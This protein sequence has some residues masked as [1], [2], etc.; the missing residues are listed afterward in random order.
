[1]LPLRRLALP[2]LLAPLLAAG[3]LSVAA[4]AHALPTGSTTTDDV[5]LYDHCQQHSISY[6]LAVDP[7][8]A[9]WHLDVLLHD[10]DG[11]TSEQ[12]VVTSATSPTRGTVSYAFCGSEKA[13]T[14]TVEAS[15]FYQGLP[16]VQTPFELPDTTFTVRPVQT[17]TTLTRTAADHG[18]Y[19]LAVTVRRE[20]EHGLE[21]AGGAPIRLERLVR[22]T[23]HQV[24]GLSLTAVRGR[25][26]T[27]LAGRPGQRVRAV[28]PDR[29]SLAGSTSKVVTL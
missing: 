11:R 12:R 5:V 7:G 19:R 17:R 18:R 27:V 2:A 14:W 21:R 9:F 10:P 29:N 20:A 1:V 6:E 13:G 15:G 25:A 26:V 24:R 8:T 4:P 22:G 23:W 28:V 16:L 3:S